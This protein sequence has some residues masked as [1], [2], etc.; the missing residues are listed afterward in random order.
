MG[1]QKTARFLRLYQLV[2]YCLST[3]ITPLI[4]V[5]LHI[6]CIITSIKMQRFKDREIA[7]KVVKRNIPLWGFV[8]FLVY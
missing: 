8:C 4:D 6:V 2:Q 3:T 1:I 5:W 7:M